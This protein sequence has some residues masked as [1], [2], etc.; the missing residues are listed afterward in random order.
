[1]I[2]VTYVRGAERPTLQLWWVDDTDALI[3]FSSGYTFSLTI[4]DGTTATVTKTSGIT[5]AAGA[6]TNPTGTPNIVVAWSASE[7][8]IA[9]GQY[10]AQLVATTGGLERIGR[11]GF[12][13]DP[14]QS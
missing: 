9:A 8:D 14:R 7:L 4:G 6:G 1:M 2:E 10:V 3:D 11:F 12:R 5:G 13:I